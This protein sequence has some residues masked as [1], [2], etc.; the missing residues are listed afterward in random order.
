MI[1]GQ[2]AK[3]PDSGKRG[4][5]RNVTEGGQGQS[6]EDAKQQRNREGPARRRGAPLP[7]GGSRP[8]V[9]TAV[10][11]RVTNQ[12][13]QGPGRPVVA[14]THRGPVGRIDRHHR[15]PGQHIGG[16]RHR[17]ADQRQAEADD[18]APRPEEVSPKT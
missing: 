4:P 7:A 12:K 1:Q 18:E 9:N 16:E 6:R 13:Q 15:K 17:E 5:G 2:S 8:S 3:Q 11:A 14:A 10:T